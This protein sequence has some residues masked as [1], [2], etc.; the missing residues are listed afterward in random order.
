MQ[1][2]TNVIYAYDEEEEK[3]VIV[4]Q[5]ENFRVTTTIGGV[6]GK[7]VFNFFQSKLDFK[8]QND[9]LSHG[10]GGG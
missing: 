7:R 2:N 5:T 6:M 9:S 4:F 8:S 3:L 1:L 10:G